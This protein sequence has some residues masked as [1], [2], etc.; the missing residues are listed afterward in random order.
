MM[1]SK[2]KRNDNNLDA[3]GTP[4]TG[5]VIDVNEVKKN[6]KDPKED[7]MIRLAMGQKV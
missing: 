7:L 6:K 5:S 1:K 3:D 2:V 4:I